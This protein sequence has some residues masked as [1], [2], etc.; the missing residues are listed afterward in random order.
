MIF[1]VGAFESVVGHTLGFIGL[2]V[3]LLIVLFSNYGYHS[4]HKT[5]AGT[6]GLSIAYLVAAVSITLLK[7]TIAFSIFSGHSIYTVG[8]TSG[9]DFADVVDVIWMVLQSVL[10]AVFSWRNRRRT[11][12]SVIHVR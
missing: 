11:P 2:Q 6:R 7:I 1:V 9:N 3:S 5:L 12:A 8:T 4:S 10:P